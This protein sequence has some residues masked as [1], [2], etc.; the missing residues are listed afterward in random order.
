MNVKTLTCAATLLCLLCL[1]ARPSYACE[2]GANASP[3]KEMKKAEAVFAGE[4]VEAGVGGSSNRYKFRVERYWKGVKEEFVVI[5][6]GYGLCARPFAVGQKWL[7]YAFE[8]ER[9]G[10]MSDVCT[11]TMPL[12][13]AA[14][15]LKALGKGK[16]VKKSVAK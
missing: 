14:D 3:R 16:A 7:V 9:E 15:D 4:V 10:L 8:D 2:C 11:R 1:A 6:V 12:A 5:S 13:E